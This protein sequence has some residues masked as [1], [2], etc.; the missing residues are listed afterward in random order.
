MSTLPPPTPDDDMP[1]DLHVP[2]PDALDGLL[3]DWHQV[4]ATQAA[5]GRDRLLA[6]LA[7]EDANAAEQNVHST[8]EPKTPHDARPRSVIA[9]IRR[10]VMNRYSPLAAAAIAIVVLLPFILPTQTNLLQQAKAVD[11]NIVMAPEGGR[12]DAFDKDGNLLGPCVLKHTDIKAEISGRF[13][14]VTLVQK[15]HN[16]HADKIEAVYTFPLSS[17]AGVDRMTMTIGD[18]VIVG[19]VKE[20][21]AAR[22]I[23]EA[24]R[25][26]GRVA[27]LL[28]QERP[29]IFTQSVANI[30]PGATIDI[31]ISSVEL[32]TERDGVMQFDFPTVVGPRYVPGG[33]MAPMPEPQPNA[34]QASMPKPRRGVVL[35]APA[36]VRLVSHGDGLSRSESS[37][38]ARLLNGA[39][40]SARPVMAPADADSNTAFFVLEAEYADGS[41]EPGRYRVD[42]YGEIGGRW[43]HCPPTPA[44]T[45][46][47]PEGKPAGEPK[48]GAPFAQPTDQVPDADRVTPMPTRPGTRAGHD[49]SISVTLDTGGPGI[50]SLESP[51]HQI[52]RTDL[53]SDAQ[54]KPR[55]VAIALAKLNEIP[56]RDF[57]L[58]WKQTDDAITDRVFTHADGLGVA[59]GKGGF[60]AIQ[61]DPPARV[62]DEQAVP[63]ELIFVVDT[64]G[65]MNGA[66]IQTCKT[67]MREAIASM[68]PLDR[69]NVITF[70]GHTRVLW[71]ELRPNTPE[72]R[73][74]ALAGIQRENGSGGTEMMRA[75][76][77]ALS[78]PQVG[79]APMSISPA[80]LADLPADGRSVT[81]AVSGDALGYSGLETDGTAISPTIKVREGLALRCD[82]FKVPT[83]SLSS[84]KRV[85]ADATLTLTGTWTTENGERVLKVQSAS[86]RGQTVRPLRIVMFLTDA[87]V[88]NEWAIIDAIKRNR[89]T[90]RVFSFGI[91]NS[92]N[93][94]LIEEMARAGGGEP[95]FVYIGQSTDQDIAAGVERFNRRTR[96]PVLTDIQVTFSGIAPTD[97]VPELANIPDLFDQ[98]PLTILGRYQ[99]GGAGSVTI[100]G[101]T[102]R[103]AWERTIPLNLPQASAEHSSLPTLW[104]RAKIDA[105]MGLDLVGIQTQ[106]PNPDV[107]SQIITLGEQF[108]VMSQYTSFVAVDKLR[109]TVGGQPRLVHVPVELPDK[110][111]WEGI[112]GP[113]TLR[114]DDHAGTRGAAEQKREADVLAI[115]SE[116]IEGMRME[117]KL[118]DLESRLGMLVFN[119][120]VDPQAVI[121]PSTERAD[122]TSAPKT[123]TVRARPA[124]DTAQIPQ[125]DLNTVLSTSSARPASAIQA[126]PSTAATPP[127]APKPA[128]RTGGGQGAP[129]APTMAESPASPRY[130]GVQADKAAAFDRKLESRDWKLADRGT[131][132]ERSGPKQYPLDSFMAGDFGS[133]VGANDAVSTSHSFTT[134]AWTLLLGAT[135][136]TEAKDF[137]GAKQIACIAM[138]AE[139]VNDAD[140]QRVQE[141]LRELTR[142]CEILSD[143]KADEKARDA[144]IAELR[145]KASAAIQ[146]ERRESKVRRTLDAALLGR[147]TATMESTADERVRV[148]MLL[149]D[150]E[151]KTLAALEKLGMRIESRHA[152]VKVVVASVRVA[153]LRE[154]ALLDA[155]RRVEVAPQ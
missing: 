73:A 40:A 39:I 66:P 54:G 142:L 15:Y 140:R 97:I 136:L 41:R 12:L 122:P 7:H 69:F 78:Q 116:A 105:L 153:T 58:K 111:N 113:N 4:H 79:S 129:S 130:A 138:S 148:V 46:P 68:R 82:A 47:G 22:R 19:E 92:V 37:P 143:P 91:G 102:A 128:G 31:E 13:A 155:V 126:P 75:I 23:Y 42:G 100:K 50:V 65:S 55:R 95:E 150:L 29:N 43:F 48:P 10:V 11:G 72:N 93:R 104:A 34:D 90:T 131:L 52:T 21:Q 14:R 8:I 62:S 112:F 117:K 141:P 118:K 25:N 152:D 81:V 88:S 147:T 120:N 107:K 17:K 119:G 63:R 18:R 44:P 101:Q 123:L 110:V 154:L 83:E 59:G 5:A 135:Q 38:D 125:I 67:L 99:V 85:N 45:L 3:R 80:Q 9:V 121:E 103:G 56:N 24:A 98:R 96:T 35:I 64:S 86:M 57:V 134:F 139:G 124:T 27:S 33:S 145:T 146:A 114:N 137:D 36:R 108:K 84:S 30:E 109:I 106:R 71:Q 115:S 2:Q 133:G 16:P 61:L 6:S 49:I 127:G 94:W 32:V 1:D 70:A 74:A 20:R 76:D 144:M 151:P 87:Y 89:S 28:E 149:S 60:V 77:A 53:A 132:D 51:L 26:A